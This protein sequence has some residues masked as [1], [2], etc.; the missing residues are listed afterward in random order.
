MR[1][2]LMSGYSDGAD[3]AGSAGLPLLAKPFSRQ[4]LGQALRFSGK[5]TM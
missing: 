4:D 1:I 3:R 5:G 2:L